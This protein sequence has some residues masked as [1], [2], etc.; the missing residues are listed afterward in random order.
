MGGSAFTRGLHRL[1]VPR[2]APPVY[3]HV[4]SQLA[5]ALR[6]LFPRIDKLIEGPEKESYGDIDILV[7]LEGSAFHDEQ[8]KDPQH[9]D[10]WAAL[11][12]ALEPRRTRHESTKAFNFRNFALAWPKGLTPEEMKTQLVVE[13][14]HLS[15]QRAAAEKHKA[16]AA[17]K[18]ADKA[19]KKAAAEGKAV[20][21][22]RAVPEEKAETAERSESS[23][24]PDPSASTPVKENAIVDKNANV[25][26]YVQV[27][28]H[29]CETNQELEWQ[30]L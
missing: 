15:E 1:Y 13:A 26:R 19:A 11:E 18:T 29:L 25:D 14:R 9:A 6:P 21:E 22:E 10:A 3:K 5:T 7:S 4:H 23:L 30:K 28:I 2:L 24:N 20:S 27:D 17:K 12:K 8:K 16:I